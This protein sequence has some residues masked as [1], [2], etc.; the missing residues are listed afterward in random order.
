MMK[1]HTKPSEKK[2]RAIKAKLIMA[3][4]AVSS[5]ITIVIIIFNF[6][7]QYYRDVIS[8]DKKIQQIKESSI[9]SIARVVWNLDIPYL[10]IQAD[11]IAKIKDLVKVTITDPK[12]QVMVKK[13][14]DP[15]YKNL[16][17][18]INTNQNDLRS[19]KFP[20][21]HLN[22]ESEFIGT[23]EIIA[24]T[25]NIK[26]EIYQRQ[27]V[28]IAGE[29]IKTLC[30]AF[31]ILLIINHYI[32]KNLD[33]V[34]EY[35]IRFNPNSWAT[36]YLTVKRQSSTRDEIDI[37]Q[38]AINKMI[39]QINTLNKEKEAKISEQEKKIDGILNNKFS[40]GFVS[41]NFSVF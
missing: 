32:N 19:Y 25:K 6:Y 35:L 10:E 18:P 14:H 24:T 26:N 1:D 37:L 5:L 38:D 36:N 20:L 41:D 21:Y 33:Q 16:D 17:N 40:F 12:G 8:L 22:A 3:V 7:N 28:L 31:L 13:Y 29:I 4:I 15:A 2:F 11:S 27:M 9:P 34:I 30:L 23:V 39:E